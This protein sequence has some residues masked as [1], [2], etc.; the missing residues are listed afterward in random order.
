MSSHH[1]PMHAVARVSLLSA[2]VLVVATLACTPP[3]GTVTTSQALTGDSAP[4]TGNAPPRATPAP[5]FT[6]IDSATS[7]QVLQYA[8]TLEFVDDV[9]RT[10]T[11][12]IVEET[13][14]ALMRISPEIGSRTLTS[15]QLHQGRITARWMRSAD[16]VRYPM[17]TMLGYIWTDSGTT[18]WRMIYFPADTAYPRMM[19]GALVVEDVKMTDGYPQAR[20]LM[21]RSGSGG[22]GGGIFPYGCYYTNRRWICP[23]VVGLTQ[24]EVTRAYNTR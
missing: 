13:R 20:S 16:S 4:Q 3:G 24:E 17:K 11:A 9:A 21:M 14:G 19:G 8:A 12:T 18:G 1:H 6:N 23:M 10:D 15:A 2:C 22:G 7:R 5:P